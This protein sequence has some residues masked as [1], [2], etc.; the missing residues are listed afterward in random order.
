MLTGREQTVSREELLQIYVTR[1][2]NAAYYR[3]SD[4]QFDYFTVFGMRY[5]VPRSE[6][7]IGEQYRFP[8][9]VGHEALPMGVDPRATPGQFLPREEAGEIRHG[10][11]SGSVG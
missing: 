1:T 10:F 2:A 7:V 6:N 9:D 11:F 3:G 8:V 5:A 4:A